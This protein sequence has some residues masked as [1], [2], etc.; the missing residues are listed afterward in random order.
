MIALASCGDSESLPTPEPADS[1]PLQERPAGKVSSLSDEPEGLV[2][3]AVTGL[4]A[5]ALRDPDR[6]VLLNAG[7]GRITTRVDL[8]ESARHLQLAA[9]GGPVLAPLERAGL[10]ARISLPDGDLKTV[11]VGKFPHDATGVGGGR[12]V[13]GNEFG[14][15]LSFLDGARTLATVPAPEQP[16]GLAAAGDMVAVVAVTERV[17]EVF[18]TRTFRS[19]GSADAGV[20]PTHIVAAR[21]SEVYVADTQGDAILRFRLGPEPKLAQ[22]IELEGTPYG[23]AL[24]APRQRLWVTQTALNRAVSLDLSADPPRVESSYP[25]VRQ[26][27]TITVDQ[28]SGR[29]FVASRT[30]SE[31]QWFDPESSDDLGP[32]PR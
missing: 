22:T 29:V 28:R 1:P 13:V 16:G 7:S 14:D 32:P 6:L 19:L 23:I 12:V 24:D 11:A 5:V 20:G 15:T 21:P 27:N 26:P 30:E 9:P 17:L 2:A 18:D 31:L 4:V 25:T 10:L 8:P 3:D